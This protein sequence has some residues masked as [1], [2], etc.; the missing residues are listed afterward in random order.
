MIQQLKCRHN[1]KVLFLK[2]F[3]NVCMPASEQLPLGKDK[4]K[5]DDL[6]QH[7]NLGSRKSCA[8]PNWTSSLRFFIFITSKLRF[9]LIVD[10]W[11]AVVYQQFE[12]EM[13][14][15]CAE[16]KSVFERRELFC[17]ALNPGT[18]YINGVMICSLK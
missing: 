10:P 17:L 1:K 7:V 18:C 4:K 3:I 2:V 5:I 12:W 9:M 16:R 6:S 15:R 13:V 11:F 14:C 8:D